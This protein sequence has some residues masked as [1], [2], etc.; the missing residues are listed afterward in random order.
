MFCALP[1]LTYALSSLNRRWDALLRRFFG[2]TEL[3]SCEDS[4][5][6]LVEEP[7]PGS[8]VC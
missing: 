6:G 7:Q 8:V 3:E 5:D 1:I 4:M 2:T